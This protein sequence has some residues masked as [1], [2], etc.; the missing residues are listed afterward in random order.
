ML[1]LPPKYAHEG[2][3][4]ESDKNNPCITCS[5]GFTA[6]KATDL[7]QTLMDR[8]GED[9]DEMFEADNLYSDKGQVATA[10]PAKIPDA[11][12][13]YAWRALQQVLSQ[14]QALAL[15]LGE[16]LSE[17]KPDVWFESP[18]TKLNRKKIGSVAVNL[19]AATRMIYDDR[20][21]FINGESY[22]ASGAD[23]KLMRAFADARTLDAAEFAKASADARELILDWVDAGWAVLS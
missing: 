9:L 11:L 18:L 4:L 16:Y 10:T 6:P 13:T 21:I 15:H 20:R 3:A 23:A 14:K 19:T 7:A 5:I 12:Q 2:V 1:Y 8:L 17:P 22:E